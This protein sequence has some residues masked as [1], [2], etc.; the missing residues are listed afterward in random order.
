VTIENFSA[1]DFTAALP[2]GKWSA[3]ADRD[4]QKCYTV[5]PYPG[6]DLAI[7]VWSSIDPATGTSSAEP[8]KDSIRCCCCKG[9]VPYGGKA[10]RWTD[11]RPGWQERLLKVLRSLATQVNYLRKSPDC[12]HCRTPLVPL[13]VRKG[14]NKGRPFAACTSKR[15]P[16]RKG[17]T[18]FGFF[19]FTDETPKTAPER[20]EPVKPTVESSA[21]SESPGAPSTATEKALPDF[22]PCDVCGKR[23][24]VFTCGP[25]TKNAGAR[26]ISCDKGRDG[27]GRWVIVD[28]VTVEGST[29]S[30]PPQR[31]IGYTE[32]KR[33]QRDERS[34]DTEATAIGEACAD[35]LRPLPP[36]TEAPSPFKVAQQQVQMDA[37]SIQVRK[38]LAL[39]EDATAAG[40]QPDAAERI[41]NC[42]EM[43]LTFLDRHG[44]DDAA[45][46][47]HRERAR[48]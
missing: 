18:G 39:L 37:A 27:C 47:V 43:A 36:R 45:A 10:A 23:C 34:Q 20:S 21:P 48:S 7:L 1:A 33:I 44:K 29:V 22:L 9:G 26:F 42:L 24:K 4:G 14:D 35:R 19:Q 41:A 11:R 15:C 3:A 38:A 17:D 13:T 28:G 25:H 2:A 5:T 46:T 16:G 12:P 6:T 8:G 30:E 40:Q 31:S 32:A